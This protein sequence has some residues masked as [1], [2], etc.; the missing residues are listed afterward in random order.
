MTHLLLFFQSLHQQIMEIGGNKLKMVESRLNVISTQID[1]AT[2]L[3][4]KASVAVKTAKRSAQ[5][6]LTIYKYCLISL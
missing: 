5:L 4:N 2:G 1:Q 3:M 6:N